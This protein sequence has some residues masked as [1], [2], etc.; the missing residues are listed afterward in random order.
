MCL[1]E[2]DLLISPCIERASEI[3]QPDI[4]GK[5]E[6]TFGSLWA[7]CVMIEHAL[8]KTDTPTT[9]PIVSLSAR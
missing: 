7:A 6:S 1:D 8:L 4:S 3:E 2:L 5:R 9:F